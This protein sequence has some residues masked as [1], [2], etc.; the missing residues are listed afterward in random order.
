MKQKQEKQFPVS[1]TL[2]VLALLEGGDKYGYQMIR[3]LESRS[4]HTFSL[5]EGTLYPIL[6]GLE[7][8]G[9]IRS[10]ETASETGRRR[11]YYQLTR[12]GIHSLSRKRREWQLLCT[13]MGKVIG[14][15]AYASV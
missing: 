10:Y 11:K 2:L 7:R 13:K 5:N 4:D 1:M 8:Q 14:G 6:H 9:E 3:E 12:Q 15:E